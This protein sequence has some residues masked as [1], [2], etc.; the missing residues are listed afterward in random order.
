[1]P[2]Y[3]SAVTLAGHVTLCLAVLMIF[4]NALAVLH[5]CGNSLPAGS[6]TRL[7][8]PIFAF[9]AAFIVERSYYVVARLLVNSGTNLWELHP[10][11]DVLSGL[12]A[13][14]A[15][16]VAAA[17]RRLCGADRKGIKRVIA[18]QGTLLAFV[19]AGLAWGLWS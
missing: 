9:G 3:W 17:V 18:A 7:A 4:W 6:A 13:I 11:P 10:A 5:I 15:F 16:W 12:V 2:L 1:M 14:G 8:T 19:Y